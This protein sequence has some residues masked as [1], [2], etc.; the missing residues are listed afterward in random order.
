MQK[1]ACYL[2]SGSILVDNT[3]RSCWLCGANS[4]SDPLEEHHVLSGISMRRISDDYGLTVY[5]CGYN[6]HR[7]GKYA[8][9]QNK[10]TRSYLQ[11]WSQQKAMEYYGWSTED[12]IRNIGKNYL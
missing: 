5:L 12:W 11:R 2:M 10:E 6:C 8:V 7:L 9:H 1:G 4:K 3:N